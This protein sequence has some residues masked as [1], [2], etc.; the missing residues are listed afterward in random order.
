MT[1]AKK[2]ADIASN[3]SV[4]LWGST[5]SLNA[6]GNILAFGSF[7]PIPISGTVQAYEWD[8]FAWTRRGQDIVPDS[9]I[10]SG[11][12]VD[13]NA[14]G[15]VL[16]MTSEGFNTLFTRVYDWNG[17]TWNQRGKDMLPGNSTLILGGTV[18]LNAQGNVVA[19]G[20]SSGLLNDSTD[21]GNSQVYGWDGSQWVQYGADII[22]EDSADHS[23]YALSISA[24]GN[25]LA[26]GA[27]GDDDGGPDA[28]N[29]RVYTLNPPNGIQ[30]ANNFS[31]A[32]RLYPNPTSLEVM[33]DLGE[34]HQDIRVTVRNMLG[35]V[36]S[37][38]HKEETRQIMTI[39]DQAPGI[40]L[41][42]IKTGTGEHA[43]MKVVKR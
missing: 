21:I 9:A 8:G 33:I 14:N 12:S 40:Y 41:V 37:E 18:S 11:Y 24:D 42:E 43:M 6:D 29:V 7:G 10:I 23:G 35:Q 1:W 30:T 31:E 26:I 25:T 28:G 20:W 36:I 22:G 2:G 13:L 39:I 5:L 38:A 4:H 19:I 16:A 17:N 34:T 3:D 15:D 27:Y 32:I